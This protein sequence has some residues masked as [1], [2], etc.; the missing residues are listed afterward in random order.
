MEYITSFENFFY[1][2]FSKLPW[3][4]N[5]TL[6]FIFDIKAFASWSFDKLSKLWIV[7]GQ[8]IVSQIQKPKVFVF[9]KIINWELND[10]VLCKSFKCWDT[11][12]YFD[13]T[14]NKYI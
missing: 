3:S 7:S 6:T 12:D 1:Y 13:L 11:N 2:I 5:Y 8:S 4:N 10:N 9:D 14:P